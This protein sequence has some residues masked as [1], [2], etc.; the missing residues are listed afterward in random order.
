M[1]L[2]DEPDELEDELEDELP[3]AEDPVEELPV[4]PEEDELDEA[5]EPPPLTVSPTWSLTAVTVPLIGATRVVSSAVFW[6]ADSVC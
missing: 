1:K 5:L 4:A 6:S 2:D 3:C